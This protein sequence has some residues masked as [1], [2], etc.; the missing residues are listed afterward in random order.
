[1]GGPNWLGVVALEIDRLPEAD[2]DFREIW[3]TIA[4]DNLSAADRMA[5]RIYEAEDRLAEFPE[6]G[7]ARPDLA[8]GLRQWPIVDYLIFY[9]IDDNRL[10]IVR[11]LHGAR[12]L[13]SLFEP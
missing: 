12:N 2:E 5:R 11:I 3:L 7:V 6:I 10:T 1:M 13:P 4:L 8:K 9:R